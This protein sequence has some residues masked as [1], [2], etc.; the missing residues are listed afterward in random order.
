MNMSTNLAIPLI[1]LSLGD[2]PIPEPQVDTNKTF[3]IHLADN[4]V[5]NANLTLALEPEVNVGI[6]IPGLKEEFTMLASAAL[7]INQ[8]YTRHENKTCL[9]FDGEV[10]L[11]AGFRNKI[12]ILNW[13][14][15][16][17]K[18]LLKKNKNISNEVSSSSSCFHAVDILCIFMDLFI[19]LFIFCNSSAL[20]LQ[21]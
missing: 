12:T 15:T 20:I 7:K 21:V 9:S 14:K 3:E 8:N 4:L 2:K 10:G 16:N 11:Y 6:T 18:Q 17:L 19:Y 5:I 1:N 13:D